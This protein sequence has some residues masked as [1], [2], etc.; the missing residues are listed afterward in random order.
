MLSAFGQKRAA[1][2][3]SGD[4][5]GYRFHLPERRLTLTTKSGGWLEAEPKDLG[6]GVLRA[7]L[8]KEMKGDGLQVASNPA[9][10]GLEVSRHHAGVDP[11]GDPKALQDR[12]VAQA[13]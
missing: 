12:G 8:P 1:G 5:P 9:S 7:F 3:A 2:R 4:P 10:V 6:T 11:S 13:E